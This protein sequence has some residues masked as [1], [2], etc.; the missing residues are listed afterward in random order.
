M[1][2]ILWL[3]PQWQVDQLTPLDR[4]RL[5]QLPITEQLKLELEETYLRAQLEGEQRNTLLLT[6]LGG[7]GG[8]SVA[9]FSWKNRLRRFL[10]HDTD[11]FRKAVELLAEKGKIEVRLGGIYLLEHIATDSPSQQAIV[12]EVL[13]AY[14]RENSPKAGDTR[15]LGS[16]EVNTL[17]VPTDIQAALTVISRCHPQSGTN[18]L[19]FQDAYLIQA[20]LINAN[21]SGANFQRTYLI[22][23]N[24]RD[25]DLQAANLRSADL[26][27]ANLSGA[28]LTQANL[29]S[30][31][32]LGANLNSAN[33]QAADL[34]GANLRGAYLGS[35]NLLETNLN[36]ADLIGVY[37]SDAN[38]S[39]AKLIGA[40]LRSAKLIGAQL[41]DTDLGEANLTGADLSD[42]NLVGADFTDANLRDVSFQ[43]TQFQETDLSGADLRGAI[44]LEVDQLAECKLCR[45]KLPDHLDLDANR[46]CA[47]LSI[48]DQSVASP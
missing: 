31:N 32:L 2:L 10:R 29:S 13:T 36:S 6:I 8:G 28:N 7:L 33:F 3:V 14:I 26:L 37:L 5:Q 22:G 20:N 38:L 18:H 19:D 15:Q 42:A 25:A 41:T 35:A 48:V 43:R 47:T 39:Q 23:T 21:L 46:D 4:N 1:L 9:Y 27:S 16:N 45:T 30:A 11:D 44:F 24:L 12:L 34:T 40:N 17:R